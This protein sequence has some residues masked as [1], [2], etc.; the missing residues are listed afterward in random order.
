MTYDEKWKRIG[1]IKERMKVL[2][3]EWDALNREN[4]RLL[5]THTPPSPARDNVPEDPPRRKQRIFA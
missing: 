1:E 3:A 5:M 2:D 4:T